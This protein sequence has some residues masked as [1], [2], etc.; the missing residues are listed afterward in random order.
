VRYIYLP[1]HLLPTSLSKS[2]NHLESL[3]SYICVEKLR[4]I[5]FAVDEVTS[6]HTIELS[7]SSVEDSPTNLQKIRGAIERAYI[8]D[9]QFYGTLFYASAFRRPVRPVS[10]SLFLCCYFFQMDKNMHVLFLLFQPL[11]YTYMCLLIS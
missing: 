7:K 3:Q 6:C 9:R 2:G 11:L 8:C 1:L 10:L 4:F 5:I